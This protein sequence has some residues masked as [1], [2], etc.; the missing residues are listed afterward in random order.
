MPLYSYRCAKCGHEFEKLVSLNAKPPVC[1][2]CDSQEVNK[3]PVGFA[4]MSGSQNSTE[5]SSC[6][7][8][9]GKFT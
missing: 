4:I 5:K 3:Q 7:S 2:K 6:S 9:G 1:P 8:S